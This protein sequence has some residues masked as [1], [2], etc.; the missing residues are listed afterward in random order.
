MELYLSAGGMGLVLFLA[1][2]LVLSVVI[3]WIFCLIADEWEKLT[4]EESFSGR[5]L[6]ERDE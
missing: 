4:C 5:D 3:V 6:M 2:S 1:S